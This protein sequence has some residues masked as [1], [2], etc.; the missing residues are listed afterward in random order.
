MSPK[1]SLSS[2]NDHGPHSKRMRTD[3][4]DATLSSQRDTLDSPD[5]IK[6]AT[7]VLLPTPHLSARAG[8]QRSIAL[9]LRHDGFDSATPQAFESL[10]GMVETCT[11]VSATAWSLFSPFLDLHSL[12]EETKR[13]ALASRR[14][15]PTPADFETALKRYNLSVSSLKPHLKNPVCPSD[16]PPKFIDAVPLDEEA[17][18][19]LPLLGV[20][21]SGQADKNCKPYIPSNFPDFPSRHTYSF[22]PQDDTNHR[23]PKKTREEAARTAQHGEDALRRLVR[24]SKMRKQKE[25]KTLVERDAQGRERFRL[26]EATMKR[27]MGADSRAEHA[28]EMEIAEHSMIVNGDASLARKEFLRLSKWPGTGRS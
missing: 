14:E 4:D 26:W 19:V 25:A 1:R 15:Q 2:G 17:N 22:T 12:I 6:G 11:F 24:A 21:L 16:I 20:E 10:T 9:A 28:Q 5:I 3:S 8:V 27:F 13:F 18:V 7:E 23:D